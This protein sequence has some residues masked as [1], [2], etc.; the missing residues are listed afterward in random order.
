MF[1]GCL[2]MSYK[3]NSQWKQAALC[4]SFLNGI[5]ALSPLFLLKMRLK[6]LE[7]DWNQI[8]IS[9]FEKSA[10]L[11]RTLLQFIR[12]DKYLFKDKVLHQKILEQRL[13]PKLTFTGSDLNNSHS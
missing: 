6:T 8:Q 4:L 13:L 11:R 12:T 10:P 7:N 3:N 1:T 2:H 9:V 5:A